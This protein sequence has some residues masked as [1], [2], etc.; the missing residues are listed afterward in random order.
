M[1]KRILILILV[2]LA[3]VFLVPKNKQEGKENSL[4][5]GK[6]DI[7]A[8]SS[9]TDL[10]SSSSEIA[11]ENTSDPKDV[12]N[13]FI[14]SYYNY[15]SESE[16]NQTT[17]EFCNEAA[18]KKLHLVEPEKDIKMSSQITSSEIYS[19][20]Q[21]DY[22]VLVSYTI[23]DNQVVPQVLKIYVETAGDS[24]KISEVQFPLMN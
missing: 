11:L 22:L 1:K 24:Y 2:V 17:K 20:G 6:Q 5:E 13:N 8:Q 23:N 18:Q 16:R 9:S 21:Y 14:K 10:T 7:T 15:S 3:V 12:I 4:P 19:G